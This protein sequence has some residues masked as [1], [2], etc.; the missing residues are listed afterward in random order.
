MEKIASQTIRLHLWSE[1]DF[2]S[3]EQAWSALLSRSAAD[4]LFMSWQWLHTWWQHFADKSVCQLRIIAAYDSH[5]HLV[6]IAPLYLKSAYTKKLVKTERLQFIGSDWYNKKVM[7]S[8]LLQFV[9]DQADAI[10]ITQHL[11][12]EIDRWQDWSELILSDLI[13]G[14]TTEQQLMEISQKDT[15]YVRPVEQFNS[16]V[17]DT[18]GDLSQYQQTLSKSVRRK[19]FRQRARLRQLGAVEFVPQV[20]IDFDD[21]F[22]TLNRLHTIR[23]QKSAFRELKLAFNLQIARQFAAHNQ[24][25]FSAVLLNGKPVSVQYNF[26]LNQQEYNIQAGFDE[27]LNKRISL[28]YLHFGYAIEAAF[29]SDTR[30]YNL[31]AGPGKHCQFKKFLTNHSTLCSHTQIVRGNLPQ[32]FFKTYDKFKRRLNKNPT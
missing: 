26:L 31:L 32:A 12:A 11:L 20:D 30:V 17:I 21:L 27:K 22:F 24:L 25:K 8:E 14:S 28:G 4:P 16:Y 9:V 10:N 6:G 2:A 23:W 3:A 7:R 19:L 29:F 15:C 1:Q 13:T 5:N 18:S